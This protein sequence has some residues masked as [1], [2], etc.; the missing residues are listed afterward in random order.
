MLRWCLPDGCEGSESG[1]M[2]TSRMSD[3]V[4]TRVERIRDG[5]A[6]DIA[7][8]GAGAAATLLVTALR[9]HHP[10]ATVAVVGTGH[11][12]GRGVPDSTTDAQHRM[13][14]PVRGLSVD[15][16]G[17]DHPPRWLAAHGHD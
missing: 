7:I 4:T 2:N 12:P 14:V 13:N 15:A 17:S 6:V 9:Q 11:S 8:V 3:L 16:D 10:W 5:D 1:G